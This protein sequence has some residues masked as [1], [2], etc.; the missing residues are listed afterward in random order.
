MA[1]LLS[2]ET[3]I[4]YLNNIA[5]K[6]LHRNQYHDSIQ[7]FKVVIRFIKFQCNHHQ[8]Q[9]QEVCPNVMSSTSSSSSIV[10]KTKDKYIQDATSRLAISTTRIFD[11]LNNTNVDSSSNTN[12]KL[13]TIE[14]SP[15]SFQEISSLVLQLKSTTI[16]KNKCDVDIMLCFPASY[17][18]DNDEESLHNHSITFQTA[19]LLYNYGIAMKRYDIS[20]NNMIPSNHKSPSILKNDND[21]VIVRNNNKWMNTMKIFQS[22]SHL[23]GNNYDENNNIDNDISQKKYNGPNDILTIDWF[24]LITTFISILILQQQN[25]IV[26]N[27]TIN[28]CCTPIPNTTEYEKYFELFDYYALTFITNQLRS[29]HCITKPAS[30]A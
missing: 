15:D 13:I 21:E 11:Q 25:S 4:V 19:L 7:T 24:H 1:S 6:L 30:S 14:L 16:M 28:Y 23:V 3:K 2:I 26:H 18:N 8:K 9:H 10:E 17:D 20:K 22:S 29:C 27:G 5:T 12:N